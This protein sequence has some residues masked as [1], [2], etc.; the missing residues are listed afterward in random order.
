MSSVTDFAVCGHCFYMAARVRLSESVTPAASS[1]GRPEVAM[2]A[3]LNMAQLCDFG[4][5]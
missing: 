5:M 4:S 2:R 1:L 3:W